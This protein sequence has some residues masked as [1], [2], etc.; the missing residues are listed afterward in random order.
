MANVYDVLEE[1]GYIERGTHPEEI[2]EVLGKESVTL[3]WF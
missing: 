3:Y 1:R 2:R